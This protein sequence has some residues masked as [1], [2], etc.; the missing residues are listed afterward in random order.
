MPPID[1]NI[2]DL[3]E[4]EPLPIEQ[5]QHKD[6]QNINAAHELMVQYQRA[7]TLAQAIL[8]DSRTPANQKAQVLASVTAVLQQVIKLQT[9]LYNSESIKRIEQALLQ[10]LKTAPPDVQAQ[11]MENYEAALAQL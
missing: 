11:F 5:A 6:L 4:D 1:Y 9:D 3:I 10:T 8:N 2:D 7:E